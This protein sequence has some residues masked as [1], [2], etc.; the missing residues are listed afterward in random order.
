MM[1]K[2]KMKELGVDVWGL[3]EDAGGKYKVE[4]QSFSFQ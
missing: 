1:A 4:S 2:Q 3:F